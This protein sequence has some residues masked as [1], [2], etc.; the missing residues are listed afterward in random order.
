MKKYRKKSWID[1]R[2]EIRPS[3]LHGRGMFAIAPIKEGEV[4]V[5]WGLPNIYTTKE[6]AEKAA[7]KG[8]AEGKSIYVGQIDEGLFTVEERGIDPTYFMNHSCDPNVWL[9]DEVTLIAR[10]DIKPHEELTIDYALME[11]D[12]DF[13]ASWKCACGS[14][15]CRKRYTGKDWRIGELRERYCGHFTPFIGKRIERAE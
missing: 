9:K 13:E 10:R 14:P 15:L 4:V 1:S 2:I 3:Q 11:T 12:E 6:D 8:R 7:A 5:I